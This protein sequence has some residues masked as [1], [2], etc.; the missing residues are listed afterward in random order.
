MTCSECK[1]FSA[2]PIQDGYRTPPYTCRR[3]KIAAKP[4]GSSCAAFVPLPRVK[5]PRSEQ[6]VLD[7]GA[8]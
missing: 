1:R 4:R 5:L 2:T 3:F 8:S 6:G 7:L